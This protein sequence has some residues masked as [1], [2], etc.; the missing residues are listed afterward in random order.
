MSVAQ[1]LLEG[2]GDGARREGVREGEGE[3]EGVSERDLESIAR[4]SYVRA[5]LR[6]HPDK[7]MHRI[8]P[9]MESGGGSETERL[10]ERFVELSRCINSAWEDMKRS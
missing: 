10:K 4:K 8:A 2:D 1:R 3:G 7:F 5:S 9:L 6:W